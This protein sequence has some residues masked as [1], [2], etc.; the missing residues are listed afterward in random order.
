MPSLTEERPIIAHIKEDNWS[1]SDYF[2]IVG[3]SDLPE[4]QVPLFVSLTLI[5]LMTL[6]GNFFIM[7]A[8]YCNS[9]LHTP[10]YFFITHLS[11][12]DIGYATVIF[13]QMLAHFHLPGTHMSL[14]E[15][16]LQSYFFMSMVSTEYVLLTVMAYDRYVAICNPLRYLTIMN[17]TL[18]M[19]LAAAS[20]GFGCMAPIPYIAL[21]S[22][23]SFCESRT[24]NHF[25]CDLTALLKIS[26]SSTKP[27]ELLTYIMGSTVALMSLLPI[28]ISYIN[29]ILSI[30]KIQSKGGRSKTF[31][32]CC[33]HL[34]VVIFFYVSLFS[35][36]VRPTSTY[37]MKDNKIL[38]LCYTAITPLSNPIIYSLKNTEIKN[39]LRKKTKSKE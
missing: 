4:L 17:W 39:A 8:I 38:T 11:F 26:C 14:A 23:L 6:M 3:F 29:I 16:L 34:T 36:Y 27:I 30:L 28:I 31:S 5:Y 18:C 21:M 35:T 33:S 13:P 7:S 24:I 9:Q 15:C 10:M 25:F 32:T 19:S 2:L 20:W 12:L 1:S 22:K 37:S